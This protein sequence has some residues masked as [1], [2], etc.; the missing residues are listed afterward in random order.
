MFIMGFVFCIL[1]QVTVTAYNYR[2]HANASLV[3]IHPDYDPYTLT[4]DI[5]IVVVSVPVVFV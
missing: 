4:A 2:H 5:S 3:Y 1:F